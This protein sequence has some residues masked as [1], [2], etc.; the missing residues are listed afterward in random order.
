MYDQLLELNFVKVFSQID[1]KCGYYQIA[2]AENEISTTS[3]VQGGQY[4]FFR[5]PLYPQ[6]LPNI[7]KNNEFHYFDHQFLKVF[8]DDTFRHRHKQQHPRR[9]FK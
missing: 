7:P 5:M 1:L 6:A 3:L 2:V 9:A 8:F 4:E